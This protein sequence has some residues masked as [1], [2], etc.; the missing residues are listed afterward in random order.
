VPG[1]PLIR[2]IVHIQLHP[3][4]CIAIYPTSTCHQRSPKHTITIPSIKRKHFEPFQASDQHRYQNQQILRLLGLDKRNGISGSTPTILCP[5]T[6]CHKSLL[7]LAN[8]QTCFYKILVL[9][10]VDP[11][12]SLIPTQQDMMV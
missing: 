7:H 2:L 12:R 4:H 8:I 3:K 10:L 1:S 9:G 6:L 5:S 11:S